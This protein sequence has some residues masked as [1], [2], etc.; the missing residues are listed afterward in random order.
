[1]ELLADA[2]TVALSPIEPGTYKV[3]LL[4]SD[5]T[6]QTARAWATVVV[7][8]AVDLPQQQLGWGCQTAPVY[9]GGTVV[10]LLCGLVARRR[11]SR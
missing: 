4:V 10:A 2:G 3:R 7:D 5:S 9:L 6:G 11:R 1:M 8:G